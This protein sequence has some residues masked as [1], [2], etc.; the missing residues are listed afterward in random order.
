MTTTQ[1]VKELEEIAVRL[2]DIIAALNKRKDKSQSLFSD[3]DTGVYDDDFFLAQ[4]LERIGTAYGCLTSACRFI[5]RV[6]N[7]RTKDEQ[8]D[9]KE[10]CF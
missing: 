2:E 4:T 8:G 1:A 9:R 10:N 6:K 3:C 5:K 7:E